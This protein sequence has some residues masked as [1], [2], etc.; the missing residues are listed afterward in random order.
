MRFTLQPF[1]LAIVQP[2]ILCKV[3]WPPRTG[4]DCHVPMAVAATVLCYKWIRCPMLAAVQHQSLP[5]ANA[6]GCATAILQ[7]VEVADAGCCGSPM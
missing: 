4:G 2:Y 5:C 3:W 6:G 1:T 7:R